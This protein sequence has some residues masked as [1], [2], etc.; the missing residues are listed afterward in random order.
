MKQQ[1][2]VP[3]VVISRDGSIHN[4]RLIAVCDNGDMIDVTGAKCEWLPTQD[5]RESWGSTDI[6]L[7]DIYPITFSMTFTKPRDSAWNKW[8]SDNPNVSFV[9]WKVR[10]H[11]DSMVTRKRDVLYRATGYIS[12]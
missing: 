6:T 1:W 8:F 7:H 4:P 10:F 5:I 2:P 9:L 11:L 12:S 3:P